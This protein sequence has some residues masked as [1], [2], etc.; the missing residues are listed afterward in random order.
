MAQQRGSTTK[1]IYATAA[2]FK[3]NQASLSGEAQ[4][5]PFVSESL[6]YS[7]NLL[8]SKTIR[9]SRNAQKPVRGNVDAAGDINF[10]LAPQY[11]RLLHHIFGS[12]TAQTGVGGA[13]NHTFKVGDLPA[14]MTI[15]K[16]FTDLSAPQYFKYT[17][18]KVNNFKFT[19]KSEGFIDCTVNVMGAKEVVGASAMDPAPVDLGH[20]PFDGFGCTI[21]EANVALGVVTQIDFTLENGLDGNTYVIDG[22]GERYSMPDGVVKVTGNITALF[23]SMDLYNKALNNTET[24]LEITL[25]NGTGA[26]T[27]GNE[28]LVITMPETIF[29]PQAPVVSGPTGVMVELPFE[30]YYN[31]DANATT[32]MAVLNSPTSW[33]N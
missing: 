29:K 26:G 5:L 11:G 20:T 9:A 18:C 25:T 12:Y 22:T 21:K 17:G 7:R 23:D 3:Q 30:A 6:R 4:V 2:S 31:D 19:A 10:E 24:S 33:Y 28:K 8:T 27:A 1:I 15:E 16:H 13:Y 32:L 14:G